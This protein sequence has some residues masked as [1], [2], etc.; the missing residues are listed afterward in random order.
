MK[1][2][3]SSVSYA[4][5]IGA[6]GLS[7]LVLAA[8]PHTAAAATADAASD[9]GPAPSQTL[10]EVV[11]TAQRRAERI[12]DVPLA[13]SAASGEDLKKGNVTN[14]RDLTAT[15]PGLVFSGQ[16][17]AAEP[18]IRGIS[19]SVSTPGAPGAIAIYVDGLY[20]SSQ[21]GNYFDLPDVER[22]EVLKGPQGALYGRN[23]T[24]GAILVTTLQPSF[25]PTGSIT[26]GDGTY[27]GGSARTSNH[28]QTQAFISGPLIADK[29]AGSIS[30]AFENAPGYLTNDLDGKS[31]GKIRSEFFRAKLLYK[32]LDQLSILLSG[33]YADRRDDAAQQAFPL[34]TVD[35]QYPG[36][37]IP[38]QPWHTTSE[39]YG[40]GAY[41][42]A[43][44]QD[45]SLK[46]DWTLPNV[47]TLT[48]RTGYTEVHP[49]FDSDVDL[50]YAPACLATIFN[51]ITPFVDWQPDASF[52]QELT[53]ASEKWGRFSF[54]AGAQFLYD[55]EDALYNINPPISA[56]P[57]RPYGQYGYFVWEESV[58][59]DA[60][61]AYFE[62]TYDITDA[63]TAIAGVRYSEETK[64]E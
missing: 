48:S 17:S 52:Q 2:R 63:L 7:S 24:G 47:G 30:A 51:C 39:L 50:A 9:A 22:I 13:I 29:L 60:Y 43:I 42:D 57:I 31:F 34:Q 16:G 15:F 32:P 28:F 1:H 46:V 45:V 5:S 14:M 55:K 18:A 20:Q 40:G 37:I 38:T 27:F 54:I 58:K 64:S 33:S 21:I 12:V 8:N 44:H 3:R 35:S 53:F 25:T 26:V 23:A 19:T 62:G 56:P 11:V 10:E 59:T 4:T 41:S 61:A 36:S 49:L 6:L